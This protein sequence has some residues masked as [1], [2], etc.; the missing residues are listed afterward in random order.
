M[1][2]PL[3]RW[4]KN[5][6][7]V[8]RTLNVLLAATLVFVMLHDFLLAD[9]AELFAGGG[10][11]WELAYKLS[12]AL[13]GSYLF[14]FVVV[15]LKKQEDKE[16]LRPYLRTR[17]DRIVGRARALMAELNKA[18]GRDTT[19]A[20]PYLD[21]ITPANVQE[22]C[23][24]VKFHDPAPLF[25]SGANRKA[26]WVEYLDHHR[27]ETMDFIA[28][29]YV[30]SPFLD[31][32]LL[33]LLVEVEHSSYFFQVQMMSRLNLRD[34]PLSPLAKPMHECFVRVRALKEYADRELA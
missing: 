30:A 29:I 28:S 17:T 23:S 33:K 16:N 21:E 5:V 32:E 2:L 19:G 22:V 1:K 26:T 10:K 20:T 27:T 18:S 8:G 6:A 7:A 13:I 25:L 3:G 4:V 24:A 14:Y 9:A 31:T 15:H 34:D 11:L 12:L